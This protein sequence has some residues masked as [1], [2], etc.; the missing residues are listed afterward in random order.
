M[1]IRFVFLFFLFRL[2]HVKSNSID[3]AFNALNRKDYYTANGLFVKASKKNPSISY[4][5]LT[6]LYLKHDFLNLDSAYQCILRSEKT[7]SVV[8]QKKRENYQKH[9]FDSLSI[10]FWKQ[11]VSDAFFE[12]EQLNLTEMGL[13]HYIDKNGWSRHVERAVF[14]RDSIAYHDSKNQ[15]SSASTNLFLSKYPNSV[16]ASKARILLQ[17]QEY[18]ETTIAGRISD[19]EKFIELF[20]SNIHISDAEN[21]IYKLSTASGEL[22]D[23]EKFIT[24]YPQNGNVNEAWRQLYR[25]Y[26]S[27]FDLAKFDSFEKEYPNF[28]FKEELKQ[29][30]L[31]FY[32]NYFPVAINE[33]YGYINSTGTIVIN[34]EYDEVGPF[35][36]GL[37]VVLKDSKFGVINKKNELVVDFKYDEIV[38]FQ[39][40]RAIVSLNQ[41]Y[42]LIDPV[43]KEI[44]LNYLNDL[45]Y[46]SNGIYV[47]LIDTSYRFL[48]KNLKVVSNLNCQEVGDLFT[49][50]AIFQMNDKYG[51]VDSSLNVKI[52]SQFD[53]IQRFNEGIFIY[54]L[55]N[56]KGLISV[57]GIKLTEPIY[58]DI[59]ELNYE[60]KTAVVKIGS[61]ISWIK[62]DGSKLFDFTAEYF[63]NALEFAQFSKGFAVFRKKGKYGFIDEKSKLALKTSL[64][65]TSKYVNA[66]PVEKDSKWG[67]IDFKGK[68]IKSYE[69]DLLEDWNGRGILVQKN[70]LSGL[71]DYNFTS[72][73]PIE[74]NSIKVFDNRYYIVT[75]DSKCGLYDFSGKLIIPIIYDRIQLFDKDCVTLINE[76]EVSYYFNR[77]NHYLKLTR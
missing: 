70:G 46:F 34:A 59:S 64:Q 17:D 24:N 36:N 20:P 26:F 68:V 29:D 9:N 19:Y 62:M 13:Q 23:Y 10:Q 6:Q 66:I 47:G 45:V 65:T 40:G 22:K 11:A 15:N 55:N 32:E 48:D 54:V 38:D 57:D 31:V 8:S 52:P 69:F 50:H 14:L 63:P 3:K 72:I 60:N 71:W 12:V 1:M 77:T 37:A 30:K 49:G 28:P 61:T 56:K 5:G 27:G 51:V 7:F 33:K 67:L 53:E 39:D 16:Y 75:K 44:S 35:K 42:N 58:D 74:F 76:N 4:F 43:G 73:L 21:R 2:S 25:N 18:R 41:M